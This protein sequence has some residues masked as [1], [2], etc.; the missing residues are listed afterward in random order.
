MKKKGLIGFFFMA[1]L[2]P[3]RIYDAATQ[4]VEI[5]IWFFTGEYDMTC[6]RDLQEQ[7]FEEIKAPDKR[8]FLYEGCAHSP[9]YEDAKKTSEILE[10]LIEK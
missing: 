7:Y 4:Q 9:V 8:F 10:S 5:P 2:P 3:S 1:A 6:N